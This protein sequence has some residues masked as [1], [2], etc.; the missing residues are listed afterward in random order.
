M[1]DECT[2]ALDNKLDERTG[3]INKRLDRMDENIKEI[4]AEIRALNAPIDQL[5]SILI[6]QKT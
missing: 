4:H 5:F 1:V 2:K 6:S 3:E